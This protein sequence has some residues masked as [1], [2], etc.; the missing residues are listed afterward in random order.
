LNKSLAVFNSNSVN[1]YGIAFTIGALESALEQSWS[2]GMPSFVSHDYH[3]PIAWSKGLSLFI[4]P[5]LVRLTGV[6]LNASNKEDSQEIYR[7]VQYYLSNKTLEYFEQYKEELSSRLG[8]SL[9][10]AAQPHMPTCAAFIDEQLAVRRFPEIFAERD[11]DGLIPVSLLTEKAPGIYE[12]DGLLVFAH[13]YFRRSLSRLNSL[14]TPF[15][16]ILHKLTTKEAEAKIALDPDMVGLS[17]SFLPHIELEYWW[18]PKFD[19]DLSKIVPGVTRHN[20]SESERL[21]HGI[22]QTEFWWHMQDQQKTLECEE[23]RDIPSYGTG[24]DSYGCRYVHSIIDSSTAQPFHLDGA[25]RLYTEEAMLERVDKDIKQAGRHSEYT[26]LWRIDGSLDVSLWK[27]LLTHYFRDNPLVGE[28]L[29]AEE[30]TNLAPHIVSE[31]VPENIM[32]KYI[33]YD[34]K[35][36]D[37]PV[38]SV[39]YQPMVDDVSS[40]RFVECFDSLL[41][42]AVELRYVEDDFIEICK[43][44][45]KEGESVGMPSGISFV[46]FDDYVHNFPLIQHIG[47]NAV[48]SAT[49]TLN[50]IKRLCEFWANQEEDRVISYN[51]AFR[52][53]DTPLN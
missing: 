18:G 14:N 42:D 44:L 25:I 5:G 13:P 12:K 53:L 38:I 50:A 8:D 3:R 52:F 19:N 31:H 24:I 45:R 1:R 10:E 11:K 20:A 48:T 29:G 6:V 34:C 21:F 46:A 17:S 28:Y 15:L 9:S 30:D 47:D 37:G 26:K 39:S 32:S 43:L 41:Q 2:V 27:D 35:K 36:G 40:K 51:I 22:S 33:P 4:E 16:E 23:L 49:Q 7:A